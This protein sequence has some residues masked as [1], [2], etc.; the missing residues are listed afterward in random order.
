ME[1]APNIL[2]IELERCTKNAAAEAWNC[3]ACANNVLVGQYSAAGKGEDKHEKVQ[4]I[5]LSDRKLC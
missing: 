1:V 5:T 4:N 2:P 3:H